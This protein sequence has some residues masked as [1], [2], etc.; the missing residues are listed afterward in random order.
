LH[1][2]AVFID[3]LLALFGKHLLVLSV[4]EQLDDLLGGKVGCNAADLVSR[5]LNVACIVI[6]LT[7]MQY[8]VLELGVA[9]TLFLF[10]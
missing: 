5:C 9:F 10:R 8:L 1:R 3:H 6:I 7:I 4:L 2:V